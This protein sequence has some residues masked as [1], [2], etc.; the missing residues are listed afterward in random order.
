MSKNP[1]A[2]SPNPASTDANPKKK[3]PNHE[4]GLETR[5]QVKKIPIKKLMPNIDQPRHLIR[6]GCIGE[7]ADSLK[8]IG[9][10][11][12]LKVR[13]LTAEEKASLR[14]PEYEGQVVPKETLAEMGFEYM[15]IGGHRRLEGAKLAG[16]EALKCEIVDIPPEKT[17]FSAFMDNN[18]VEMDWWDLDVAIEVEHKANPKLSQRQ[19]AKLLGLSKGKVYNAL[20]LTS[21]LTEDA[22][23]SIM[24]NKDKALLPEDYHAQ[25]LG[26]EADTGVKT[27]QPL[28]TQA[29]TGT[30]TAQPLGAKIDTGVTNAQPLGTQAETGDDPAQQLGKEE[31]EYLITESILLILAKLADPDL[32]EETLE[33]VIDNRMPEV[34]AKKMVEWV[35]DGN[36]A[37]DFDTKKASNKE[38]D[39][40]AEAWKGL[41]PDIKVKHKGGEAYE[42]H[43]SVT[44]GQ[45][46]L[47]TAQAAQRFLKGGLTAKL[48]GFL[49]QEPKT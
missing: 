3:I 16:F 13:P 47:E 15:V 43:L 10:Q 48:V 35:K 29:E 21:L 40:M 27:A 14:K 23:I 8:A 45:K 42:I 38:K 25:P 36:E 44:G 5:V 18:L 30:D 11:T 12:L 31:P 46:A 4:P 17:H 22:R 33:I 7:M 1:K 24:L 19:L 37:R 20:I 41:G 9:Q 6:P 39:P 34:L 32:I 2:S 26:A 28:G 49:M